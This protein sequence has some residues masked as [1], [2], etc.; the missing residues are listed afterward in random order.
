MM[1]FKEKGKQALELLAQGMNKTSVA[2]QLKMDI[3]TVNKLIHMTESEIQQ[4]FKT[5]NEIEQQKIELKRQRIQ[6]VQELIKNGLSYTE[7]AS[8][9]GLCRQTVKKYASNQ[10]QVEHA[11]LGVKHP[12]KLSLYHD[13]IHQ[14][15]KQGWT[16]TQIAKHIQSIGCTATISTIAHHVSKI[17]KENSQHGE[18]LT[19]SKKYVSRGAVLSLI[20][21]PLTSNSQIT[22]DQC[23]QLCQQYPIFK[24]IYETV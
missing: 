1:T 5:R 13:E 14:Q 16:A 2:K 17:K 6:E 10:V 15:F 23:E 7:I 19:S 22:E 20:F 21:H 3:R 18:S 8:Q 24:T 12:S 4:F 9:L 11:S